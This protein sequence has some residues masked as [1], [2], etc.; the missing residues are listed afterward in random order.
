VGTTPSPALVQQVLN[1]AGDDPDQLPVLQHVL[2]R[3]YREWERAGGGGRLELAH[4]TAVGEIERA[5][6][7]HGNEILAELSESAQKTAATLFRSLTV[8]Q[9]GVALRR[10]RRLQQLY[11]VAGAATPDARREVDDIVRLFSRGDNSF[12][13]LSS[14]ELTPTTVADIT[15]ES[16]IRKWKKLEG[17]VREETR[18]AEWYADLSRDVVRYRSRE[19]SL[20]QDPEL[21]GV[22]RRRADEGWNEAWANQYR[23]DQDPEFAETLRFLDESAATQAD[24]IRREQES[25]DRELEQAR[26]LARARRTQYAVAMGLLLVVGVAAVIL[27]FN[28]RE[29]N[30]RTEEARRATEQYSKV[31]ADNEATRSRLA[32]QE[33]ELEKLKQSGNPADRQR[34]AELQREVEATR[35]QAKGSE[36]ELTK[37]RAGQKQTDSD[38]S[39]LLTRIDALQ[40]ERDQLRQQVNAYSVQQAQPKGST[41]TANDERMTVLQK[42]LEDERRTSATQLEELTRLRNENASLRNPKSGAAVTPPPSAQELTKAYVDGVRSFELKDFKAA[43]VSL[44]VALT[45]H[46]ARTSAGQAAPKEVRLSGTRFVPFTPYSYLAVAAL[47]TKQSCDVVAPFVTGAANEATPADLRSRLAD[48]RKACP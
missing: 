24:R 42:Q 35:L 36:D 39:G 23:R 41:P 19:V 34:L 40:K 8:A 44:A 45:F 22:Q 25:R 6:D 28:Y 21:A 29:L 20:W 27:F 10:P 3:T 26:A 32:A 37:I 13:M 11:D 30:A 1:D 2:L 5:L 14:R 33:A 15:H 16:L 12:L 4:Y 48:A 47:E 9:G 46:L 38:R 7:V 18:S 31:L 43:T 17:W